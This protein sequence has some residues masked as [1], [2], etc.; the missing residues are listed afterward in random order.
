MKKKRNVIETF[1]AEHDGQ[2][3]TVERLK[4]KGP[5][6]VRNKP[7]STSICPEC[8]SIL[9]VG[10]HGSWECTGNQLEIWINQFYQYQR[11]NDDKK[12]EFLSKISDQSRFEYLFGRWEHSQEEDGPD[13]DCGYTNKLYP[14]HSAS[15]LRLPDP[16]FC[17]FLERRL[18]RKLTEEE[19][20]G[21]D[22]VYFYAGQYISKPRKG[23]KK[24]RIPKITFP[25]DC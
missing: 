4:P 22:H 17:K 10:E 23:A 7:R 15:K 19:L 13:F 1:K 9:K 11:L 6:K 21:E 5:K 3:V 8:G 12:I 20:Y 16:I 25:D 18:G 14:P 24:I 2:V